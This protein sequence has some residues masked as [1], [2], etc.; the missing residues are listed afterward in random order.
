MDEVYTCV[1]GGQKFMI[2]GEETIICL[3]C[4]R[5]YDLIWIDDAQE[6]AEDFNSRIRSKKE[7]KVDCA[8]CHRI[9]VMESLKTRIQVT[10]GKETYTPETWDICNDCREKKYPQE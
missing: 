5:I 10:V 6:S 3:K 7:D 8:V 2:T 1:C 9:I 4:A